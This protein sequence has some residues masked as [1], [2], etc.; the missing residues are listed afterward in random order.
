MSEQEREENYKA[1]LHE[2]VIQEVGCECCIQL[3]CPAYGLTK[4]EVYTLALKEVEENA[5]K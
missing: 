2:R 4:D 3:H 5:Q 1:A